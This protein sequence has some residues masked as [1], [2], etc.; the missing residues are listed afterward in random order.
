MTPLTGLAGSTG[1][2][3]T[4]FF[5]DTQMGLG[6]STDFVDTTFF[7]DTLMGLGG[8]TDFWGGQ[9]RW[10]PSVFSDLICTGFKP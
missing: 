2:V 1:F 7:F 6:G 4:T 9:R 5:F 8:S 3:V 10:N